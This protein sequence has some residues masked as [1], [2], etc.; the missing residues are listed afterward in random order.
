MKDIELVGCEEL[1]KNV[2]VFFQDVL[3]QHIRLFDQSADGWLMSTS[4]ESAIVFEDLQSLW[5]TEKIAEEPKLPD[6]LIRHAG[7]DVSRLYSF[8][9]DRPSIPA[10]EHP[11]NLPLVIFTCLKATF[12]RRLRQLRVRARVGQCVGKGIARIPLRH[13]PPTMFDRSTHAKLITVYEFGI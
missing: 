9:D 1:L 11:P 6:W 7:V 2:F 4:A 13:H 10:F 12:P 3:H 8:I 5:V